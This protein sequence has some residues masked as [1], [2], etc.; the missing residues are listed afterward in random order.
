MDNGWWKVL[1]CPCL[2]LTIDHIKGTRVLPYFKNFTHKIA[3]SRYFSAAIIREPID[4]IF[5][6][7]GRDFTNDETTDLLGFSEYACPSIAS[8]SSTTSLLNPC[9][10]TS[11]RRSFTWLINSWLMFTTFLDKSTEFWLKRVFFP[12]IL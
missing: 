11:A 5:A 8:T 6:N 1:H 3:A 10:I 2:F 12:E 9:F 7:F 4:A